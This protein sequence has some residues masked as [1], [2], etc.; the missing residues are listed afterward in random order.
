MV[1]WLRWSPANIFLPIYHLRK[2]QMP[3]RKVGWP[4]GFRCLLYG[5]RT[6][7]PEWISHKDY[8]C[9]AKCRFSKE[10]WNAVSKRRGNRYWAGKNNRCPLQQVYLVYLW[11][12]KRPETMQGYKHLTHKHTILCQFLE[13]AH[14]IWLTLFPFDYFL[15]LKK[16]KCFPVSNLIPSA[17]FEYSQLSTQSYPT[18]VIE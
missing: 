6:R 17:Q 8:I 2:I 4:T 16:K 14:L 9:L 13:K 3:E 1:L 18:P 7:H 5:Q 11:W 10:N 12:A 15:A